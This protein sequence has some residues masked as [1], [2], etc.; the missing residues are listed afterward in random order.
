[1]DFEVNAYARTK[2]TA[3]DFLQVHIARLS[4]VVMVGPLL[5]LEIF[6]VR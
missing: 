1:M 2:Q 6:L 5:G 4:V 3:G